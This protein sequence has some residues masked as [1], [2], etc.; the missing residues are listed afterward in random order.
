M[1]RVTQSQRLLGVRAREA[2]SEEL[3]YIVELWNLTRTAPERILGRAVSIG[4]AKVIFDAARA[5]H[6]DRRILLRQGREVLE[7]TD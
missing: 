3:P 7:A 1:I 2:P 6:I 4:L 5:E